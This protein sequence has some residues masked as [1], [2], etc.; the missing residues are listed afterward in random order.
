LFGH[1]TGKTVTDSFVSLVDGDGL[2]GILNLQEKLDSLDGG[3][4]GLGDGC[5]N[6]SDEEVG[7]EGPLVLF[8]G[9]HFSY[10]L[11]V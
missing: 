9:A 11:F 5:G 8:W 1:D 6:T 2:A 7:G 4:G 3:D 10:C